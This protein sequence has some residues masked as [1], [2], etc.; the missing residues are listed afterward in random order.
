MNQQQPQQ[1][2]GF[3][4][5]PGRWR[6]SHL[7][8]NRLILRHEARIL[9]GQSVQIPCTAGEISI[10]RCQRRMKIRSN[11]GHQCE[12]YLIQTFGF[13]HVDGIGEI[14]TRMNKAMT[15]DE[16]KALPEQRAP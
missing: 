8:Q 9:L 2:N 16:T 15:T 6:R 11:H 13:Q 3:V 5:C 1:K 10:R 4:I 12:Q 14:G 7:L